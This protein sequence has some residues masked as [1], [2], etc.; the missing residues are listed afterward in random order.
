MKKSIFIFLIIQ[1]I[2]KIYAYDFEVH[3][4]Y[5]NITDSVNNTV[6]VTR[7]NS[8]SVYNADSLTIPDKIVVCGKTYKVKS[9]GKL[10]FD[11]CKKL[12]SVILPDS[13]TNIGN[14]SF[15]GCTNLTS[16]DLPNSIT[17]ID[18]FAFAL[19]ESLKTIVLPNA[20]DS[21]ADAIFAGCSNLQ[22][23]IIPDKV[24]CIGQKAFFL[25]SDLESV[26]IP[27]NVA[28]LNGCAT[29][30]NCTNLKYLILKNPKPIIVHPSFTEDIDINKCTL[31]VPIGT[32]VFYQ[33][34]DNWKQFKN[35]IEQSIFM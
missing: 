33:M 14:S 11:N 17:S 29:F 30:N 27:A 32:K 21:V 25:C 9:I 19:C 2:F 4:I 31:V 7:E 3:G 5:Y 6:E 15:A 34:D 8:E 18:I 10:A 35:I 24:R 28:N 1:N 20:I 13:I 22:T 16:I 23:V 26:T 12:R